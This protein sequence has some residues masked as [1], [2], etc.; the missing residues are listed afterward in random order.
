MTTKKKSK[1]DVNQ[2]YDVYNLPVSVL[3]T[4]STWHGKYSTILHPSR[5]RWGEKVKDNYNKRQKVSGDKTLPVATSTE[6]IDTEEGDA[7]TQMIFDKAKSCRQLMWR[8]SSLSRGWEMDEYDVPRPL[9]IAIP[10]YQPRE[11]VGKE[12]PAT[13]MPSFIIPDYEDIDARQD[14][15]GR[16]SQCRE[17]PEILEA[18][19]GKAE[20]KVKIPSIST[21]AFVQYTTEELD[22]LDVPISRRWS[23]RDV[24][25]APW[26]L[27]WCMELHPKIAH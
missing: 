11:D 8:G 24:Q 23:R 19:L 14:R 6:V 18:I 12:R 26:Y 9:L 1:T 25:E 13:A 21:S 4:L 20:E 5:Q 10:E 16:I 22:L 3:D 7:V 2:Q 27:P 17:T 15:I